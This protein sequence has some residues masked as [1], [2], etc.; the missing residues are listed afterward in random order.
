[1][2]RPP[3]RLEYRQQ[4]DG[5]ATIL[6]VDLATGLVRS[7]WAATP[8]ATADFLDASQDADDWDDQHRL[9]DGIPADA[10]G[11][12]LGWRQGG[13]DVQLSTDMI[14]AAERVLGSRDN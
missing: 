4:H 3:V 2:P 6:L 8:K 1:M 13:E 10:F 11:D 5:H 7:R 14:A 12:L 9:D